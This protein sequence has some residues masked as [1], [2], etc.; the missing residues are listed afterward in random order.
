MR[1]MYPA[2]HHDHVIVKIG[3][4]LIENSPQIITHC[5]QEEICDFEITSNSGGVDLIRVARI[6]AG[7]SVGCTEHVIPDNKGR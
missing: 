2:H 1:D 7:M 6:D 3:R 4:R 5:A